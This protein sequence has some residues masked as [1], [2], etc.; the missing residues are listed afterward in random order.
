MAQAVTGVADALA[1]LPAPGMIIG[2]IAVILHGVPRV[3]RDVDGTVDAGSIELEALASYLR[4]YQIV[5]R[6]EDAVAFAKANQVLLLRHEPTNID[7]DLSLAWLPFELEAIAAREHLV[8]RKIHA[9]IATPED[10]IIYT[11]IAWR[12]QGLSWVHGSLTQLEG[13]HVRPADEVARS[14]DTRSA[15]V[16]ASTMLSCTRLA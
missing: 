3:T 6:I 2:G 9:D 14:T 5:P 16:S 11:A 12:P 10:L 1:A 7:G 8:R 4:R 15:Q 13:Q